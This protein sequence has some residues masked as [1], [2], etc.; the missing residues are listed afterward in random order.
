MRSSRIVPLLLCSVMLSASIAGCLGSDDSSKKDPSPIEMVVYYE[1]TS[2]TIVEEIRNGQ[3]LSED[4]VE[5]AFDFART[6]SENG[7]MQNFYVVPGDGTSQLQVNADETAEIR[8]TYM[9]HGLFTVYLGAID[10]QGNDNN[11]SITVRIE[12]QIIW[13]DDNTDTPR[14]MNID[15]TPDCDCGLPEFIQIESTVVN[16]DDIV[17]G[18]QDTVSWHLNDPA[19][20]EQGTH[21][22]IIGDSQDASWNYDQYN[23]MQG[24]WILSVTID[25]GT[26]N[27]DVSHD[28]TIKYLAEE[29]EANPL[30]VGEE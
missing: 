30:P 3:Q 12:K 23:L 28:V 7:Q 19:E 16:R 14:E 1:T 9:T 15:A 27:I 2:G 8:Y 24:I 25:Q 13:S 5:L 10:D 11:I 29:S 4:G 20:E 21:T 6:T 18:G 17:L 22:E 26:D